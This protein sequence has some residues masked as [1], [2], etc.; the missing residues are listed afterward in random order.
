MQISDY[1]LTYCTNIHPG[2]S[3]EATFENLKSYVPKIK[4]GLSI[5]KRFAIGLRLSDEA[6]RELLENNELQAFKSWLKANNCYVFTLNG[7]PYGGFHRQVVKDEVHQPDW[8]TQARKEYTLRLFDILSVLMPGDMDAGISTSPLS[9][10]HWHSTETARNEIIG[11]SC[12][13]I[14]E[15]VD[16]LYSIKLSRK[17]ILHLDI[18]P[19]PDGM[20]ENAS[21]VHEFFE[22]WLI[23]Q[24]IPM[25]TA[26]YGVSPKEA[27]D[28]IKD[29]VRVCYDVCHFAVAYEDHRTVLENF[30]KEGIKIGK[31]QLSAA[32]KM[33]I[34]EKISQRR[35]VEKALLPFVESTYLHQ[36]IGRSEGDGLKAYPDLPDAL[37]ALAETHD[38]EWRIHFHVP[39]FLASYGTL[40]S[41]Q[42]DI[43]SV[44]DLNSQ[45]H[46]SS[47][48]EVETYT[49]E[50][51]P[52]D[53][54]LSLDQSIVRELDWAKIHIK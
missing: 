5:E 40:Q 11:K 17:Q 42:E 44:L 23:P 18:E 29:H 49:W 6:S 48:L 3:W 33:D 52:E 9:Y 2:E 24:G 36:V 54:H 10:K 37:L 20:I 30:K 12:T 28:I 45:N 14:L 53:I 32:L 13:Q 38:R 39:V 21:G 31:F 4:D 50:V 27:M 25:L 15:V 7:F 22:K 1:H 26:K 47:Q 41:T 51:L 43:L 8:T 35:L 16:Y 46:Y 34:P 19:E